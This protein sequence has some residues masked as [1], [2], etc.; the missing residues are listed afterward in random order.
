MEYRAYER[1]KLIREG[2]GFTRGE[3]TAEFGF[4]ASRIGNIEKG[5][6]MLNVDDLEKIA[7][8]LPEVIGFLV[9]GE[10][11]WIDDLKSSS[12]SKSKLL[13]S[14]YESGRLASYE[15]LNSKFKYRHDNQEN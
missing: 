1:L 8:Q 15:Y 14:L 12:H 9:Y 3:F 11:I 5:R 4:E 6:T 13:L 7:S 10:D 2:M